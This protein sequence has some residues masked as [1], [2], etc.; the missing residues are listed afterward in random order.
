MTKSGAGRRSLKKYELTNLLFFLT[1]IVALGIVVTFVFRYY[2]N[3]NKG[4]ISDGERGIV[5]EAFYSGSDI[6]MFQLGTKIYQTS[7]QYRS[8]LEIPVTDDGF[9]KE[10]FAIEG[11]EEIMV[12]QKSI[13]IKKDT[14]TSWEKIKPRV[15]EIVL[16]HLHLHY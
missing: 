14:S 15:Q 8:P 11:V 4:D 2:G 9:L 10:L 6:G 7:H 13:M 5:A 12:D 3:R 16:K 1:L